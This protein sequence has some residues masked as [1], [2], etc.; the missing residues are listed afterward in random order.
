MPLKRWDR[1]WLRQLSVANARSVGI[2]IGLSVHGRRGG[3]NPPAFGAKGCSRG[4]VGASDFDATGSASGPADA[5]APSQGRSSGGQPNAAG[6]A[7]GAATGPAFAVAPPPVVVEAG[8][9]AIA[10]MPEAMLEVEEE[11]GHGPVLSAV[12]IVPG[13]APAEEGA[14]HGHG[15]VYD[16]AAAAERGGRCV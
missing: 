11:H 1:T 16:A 14:P 5:R 4:G 13:A 6:R 15:P 3:D 12:A 7:L 9:S 2:L 10:P 8:S